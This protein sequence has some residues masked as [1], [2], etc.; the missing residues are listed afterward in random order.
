MYKKVFLVED[1]ILVRER[2]RDNIDWENNGFVFAGE[3]SNG[4]MA[5]P[6]IKEIKPDI[7]ITDI[8]MQFMDGLEL[9]RIVKKTMSWIKIIIL[10]GYDEF[11]YAKEAITINVNEYLLKPVSAADLIK[12]LSHISTQIDHDKM[13]G[14]NYS[15][16]E[17]KLKKSRQ[18][19]W[20]RYLSDLATGIIPTSEVIKKA[21]YFGVDIIS[22]YY[23]SLII[24]LDST[25][26][27]LNQTAYTEYLKAEE[28]IN[29]KLNGSRDII[30]YNVNIKKAILIFKHD[31]K[32]EL[33]MNCKMFA[34]A[35]KYEIEKNTSCNSI[36]TIGG[37]RETVQ[38]IAESI[39]DAETT[40][41]LND[42]FGKNTIVTIEGKYGHIVHKAKKFIYENYFESEI[43]L[44]SVAD[45][46]NLSPNHLSMI[47]SQETG[48]TFIEY[49]T[50]LRIAKA[51]KMLK[52]T[53]MR[54]S[55]I[56]FKVGYNDPH[57]F[58]N[59]FKKAVGCA[60]TNFRE[61][62]QTVLSTD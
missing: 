1:E 40:M 50:K 22:K 62:I 2:V 11:I 23:C 30:K 29:E 46:V 20:E 59:V 35:L 7:L 52:S 37:I 31:D 41:N 36:I 33:E 6:L 3:A 45:Y 25:P 56:A 13:E 57:Y 43:S 39:R 26:L 47:F 48:L 49:L 44:N 21:D 34:Q 32:E 58:S 24:L 16:I 10:S 15:V 55:E 8:K 61:N 60:P 9:S 19:L 4:E 42:V 53:N 51:K 38:G 17:E 28:I 18:I 14:K 12:T 54:T 27:G 5:L